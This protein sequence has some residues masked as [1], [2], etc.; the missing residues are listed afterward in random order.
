MSNQ[1]VYTVGREKPAYS[2]I[3]NSQ[4]ADKN[5]FILQ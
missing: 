1:G 2:I 4:T 3:V 5:D